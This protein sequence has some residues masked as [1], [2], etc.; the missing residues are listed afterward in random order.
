M[1]K[2]KEITVEI[3]KN[4]VRVRTHNKQVLVD[5]NKLVNDAVLIEVAYCINAEEHKTVCYK[6]IRKNTFVNSI[7][8]KDETAI[9][10]YACLKA[11]FDNKLK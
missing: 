1:K 3:G 11:Y 2:Q 4:A 10:L 7:S 8:L 9:Q 6:K 5:S